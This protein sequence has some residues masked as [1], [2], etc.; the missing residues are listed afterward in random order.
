MVARLYRPKARAIPKFLP[1][2]ANNLVDSAP[3]SA[4]HGAHDCSRTKVKW[5][6]TLRA[7][8]WV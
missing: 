7:Q 8:P 1:G 5:T 6:K 2:C 3:C 4:K